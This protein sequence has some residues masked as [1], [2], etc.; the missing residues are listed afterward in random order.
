[1]RARAQSTVRGFDR[2]AGGSEMATVDKTYPRSEC[3]PASPY[4]GDYH[5]TT[6][7]LEGGCL[8]RREAVDDRDK[9]GQGD[10][11]L[12]SGCC[13]HQLR[14]TVQP[15]RK[16]GAQLASAVVVEIRW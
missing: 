9:P 1:M 2:D 3:P 12:F 13:K 14:S 7:V 10:P 5:H 8:D 15:W 4:I 11:E 6:H 16:A